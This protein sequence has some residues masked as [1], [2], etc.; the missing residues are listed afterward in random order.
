MT[1]RAAASTS[2]VGTPGTRRCER[3]RLRALDEV[4]DRFHL[5]GRFAQDERARD[6]GGV[7]L[8]LATIVEHQDGALAE[9]LRLGRAVREQP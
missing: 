8:D 9:S 4:E 6:V 3:R 2:A 5:V 7:A 1:L